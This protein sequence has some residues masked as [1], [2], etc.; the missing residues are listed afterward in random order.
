MR[1]VRKG[2]RRL[3]IGERMKRKIVIKVTE[4]NKRLY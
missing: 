1:E 3:P 4:T 2:H